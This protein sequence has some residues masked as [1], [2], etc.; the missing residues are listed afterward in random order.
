M[1]KLFL[2]FT[3]SVL[4]V[5]CEQEDIS[6]NSISSYIETTTSEPNSFDLKG[7]WE[8]YEH[9]YNVPYEPCINLKTSTEHSQRVIVIDSVVTRGL[10]NVQKDT[11]LFNMQYPITSAFDFDNSKY[12][13]YNCHF[14]TTKVDTLKI[15][16]ISDVLNSDTIKNRVTYVKTSNL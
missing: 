9:C 11:S 14:D 2:L 3:V 7:F 5:S 10:I 13:G 15:L 8:E 6:P 16:Y 1:K 12:N 4:F